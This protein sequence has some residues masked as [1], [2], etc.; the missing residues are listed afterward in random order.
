MIF[1][2]S[3]VLEVVEKICS[4][5]LILRKGR[6][7]AHDRV[8]RLRDL[9]DQGSRR[10]VRA[11]YSAGRS[12]QS[13][14]RHYCRHAVVSP[15]PRGLGDR[16][17]AGLE[18]T[19]SPLFELCRH[20]LSRFFDSEFVSSPSQLRVLLNEGALSILFSLVLIFSQAYYHKYLILKALDDTEPY[21]LSTLADIL[22]VIALIMLITGLFTVLQWPS[23]FPVL[24]DYLALA[25]L[26]LRWRDV[27]VAKFTALFLVAIVTI[28]VTASMPSIA[29]PFVMARPEGPGMASQVP[30]IFISA[31]S[32]GLFCL[33]L[34][35][36]SAGGHVEP[37]PAS[38]SS[39]L[40]SRRPFRVSCSRSSSADSRSSFRFQIF[41]AP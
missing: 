39:S 3:H 40:V 13:G 25:A 8:E 15:M 14:L 16:L 17:S 29:L 33:L 30:A 31:V 20:F 23:L 19:H 9:M 7:V 27:F 24:R 4:S 26:P 10:C 12:H 35:R 11:T 2:S 21:R 41:T 37:A 6:A 22:F 5:V 32:A 28:V 1:Y 38:G 34:A 18:R 36:C